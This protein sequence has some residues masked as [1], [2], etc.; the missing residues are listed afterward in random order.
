MTANWDTRMLVTHYTIKTI[1]R[2][3]LGRNREKLIFY[4]FKF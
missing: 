2:H 4:I 1:I 3:N